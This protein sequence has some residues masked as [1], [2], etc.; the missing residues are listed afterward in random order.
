[1]TNYWGEPGGPMPGAQTGPGWRTRWKREAALNGS[2]RSKR[3]GMQ[4]GNP[5]YPWGG[6][7]RFWQ[8]HLTLPGRLDAYGV[9]L[10][11][12]PGISIGFNA[13]VAWTHT[14]SAVQR[15]TLYRLRL[16]DD[17]PTAYL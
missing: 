4:A 14:V 13:N 8:K 2:E 15:H 10:L 9:S 5:H 7:N 12:A 11:G 3:C 1:M 6:S 16:A 17:D